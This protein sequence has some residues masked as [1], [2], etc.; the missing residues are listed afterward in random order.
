MVGAYLSLILAWAALA[1][2]VARHPALGTKLA[3]G[4]RWLLPAIMVVVG[5]YVLLNTTTDRLA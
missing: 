5:I 3:A 1:H 2:Y 4:G